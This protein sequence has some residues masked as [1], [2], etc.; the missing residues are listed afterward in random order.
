MDGPGEWTPILVDA[1]G[2]H[3]KVFYGQFIAG[4]A[5]SAGLFLNDVYASLRHA[6]FF[7]RD[8]DWYV[9]D[10]GSTNGTYVDGQ[11]TYGP[12]QLAKGTRVRIGHTRLVVVPVDG[13]RTGTPASGPLTRTTISLRRCTRLVTLP[14]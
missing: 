1:G 10:L 11:L 5:V 12:R 2:D 8:G 6:V 9:A 13:H 3:R 7:P 4:S 14:L